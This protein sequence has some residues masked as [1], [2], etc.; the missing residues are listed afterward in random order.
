MMEIIL[1]IVEFLNSWYVLEGT[2]IIRHDS[3][4]ADPAT[5][6]PRNDPSFAGFTGP[7]GQRSLCQ[8]LLELRL[9]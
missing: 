9:A 7:V 8:Q 1:I 5:L 2:P 6:I 3:I 4:L